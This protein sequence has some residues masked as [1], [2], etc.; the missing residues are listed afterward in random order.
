MPKGRS[1]V[2]G[3]RLF[4]KVGDAS[5]FFSQMLGRYEAGAVVSAE[6]GVDLANL[7]MRH[8]EADDKIA[9]G[10]SYFVVDRAPEPFPGKCFWLI[11]KDGSKI[12]FAIK[13]CLLKHPVDEAP[14]S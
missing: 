2:V 10:M 1:V 13:H 12:D 4:E 9:S 5:A 11:R 14:L 7:L 6:D 8:S 3:N